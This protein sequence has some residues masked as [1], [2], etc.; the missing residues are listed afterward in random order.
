MDGFDHTM[1]SLK[2]YIDF[3]MLKHYC[4]NFFCFVLFCFSDPVVG[5]SQLLEIP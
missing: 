3:V 2:V 5:N 4:R 1:H